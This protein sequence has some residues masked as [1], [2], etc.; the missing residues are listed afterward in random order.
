MTA[1]RIVIARNEVTKQ[2]SEMTHIK[3]HHSDT[4]TKPCHFV[5]FDTYNVISQ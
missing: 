3:P 1:T 4:G 5:L 2:S